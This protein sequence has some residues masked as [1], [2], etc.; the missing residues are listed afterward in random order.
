MIDKNMKSESK[1]DTPFKHED[2]TECEAIENDPKINITDEIR[3]A[4]EKLDL[5]IKLL[6]L[7]FVM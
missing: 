6:L 1:E 4:Y 3:Q 5:G 7:R 2:S